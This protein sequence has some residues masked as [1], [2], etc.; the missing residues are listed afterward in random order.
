MSRGGTLADEW[1]LHPE[2]M[3]H[4]WNWFEKVEEDV[5]ASWNNTHCLLW[6]SLMLQDD[7]SLGVDTFAHLPWGLLYAFPPLHLIPPLLERVRQERLSV[8]LIA[9][10]RCSAPWYAEMTQMLVAQTSIAMLPKLG[11]PLQAWLLRGPG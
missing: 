7:P 4:I 11:Q 1:K 8:I 3:Q 10:G 5:F 9:P 2:V 6:F